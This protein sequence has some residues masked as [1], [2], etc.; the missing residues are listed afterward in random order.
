MDIINKCKR[1]F[2]YELVD[3]YLVAFLMCKQTLLYS[4]NSELVYVE[5]D[6]KIK[7]IKSHPEKRGTRI[8]V[9]ELIDEI[10]EVIKHYYNNR[11]M[12]SP[13]ELSQNVRDL[14]SIIY[15]Y[16]EKTKSTTKE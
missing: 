9:L 6:A 8:F 1:P 12:V 11:V 15:Q 7:D 2:I 10:E 5:L 3:F 4:Q 16:K 13:K 14:K